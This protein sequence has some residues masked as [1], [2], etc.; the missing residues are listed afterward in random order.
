MTPL[1]WAAV[2]G[3]K[4]CIKHLIAAGADMWAKEEQGK[5][6]RDMAEELKGLPPYTAALQEAGYTATGVAVVPVLSDV[7]VII[8]AKLI[9]AKH[10]DGVVRPPYHRSRP[11]IQDLRSLASLH[12]LSLCCGRGHG[13]AICEPLS[14]A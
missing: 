1:H 3:S 12:Q 11:D 6:P 8:S 9:I 7:S 5:T 2:K 4:A 13:H 10:H 14:R